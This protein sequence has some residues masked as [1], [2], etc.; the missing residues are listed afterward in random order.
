M[1]F[2]EQLREELVTAAARE[3]ARTGPRLQ[4]PPLRPVA[5]AAAGLALTAILVIAVAGGLSTSPAPDERPVGK[6]PATGREL[7]PGTLV[8]GDRYRTR[9]FV[10]TLSFAVGDDNWYTPDSTSPDVFVL[11][12]VTRGRPGPAGPWPTLVFQRIGELYDPG[13]RRLKDARIPAPRDLE[14]WFKRH[15]DLR[16]SR[17]EPVTVA[18]VSGVSF[19]VEVRFTRPTH[20]DPACRER[21]QR[22]CTFLGPMLSLFDGMRLRMIQLRT[23][24]DP[25]TIFTVAM[26]QRRLD[27][28]NR[29][30]APVLDSLRIGIR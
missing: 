20:D 19:F 26:S 13:V 6:Q 11:S 9:G 10:P 21:F 2:V 30:A 27:A 24:P 3:Q 17:S 18:G 16:V 29:V 22:R 12:R 14:A 4:L 5:I 25:L 23:E 15:P 28:L 1:S 7:F 8:A